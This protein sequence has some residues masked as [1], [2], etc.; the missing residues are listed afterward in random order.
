M[1]LAFRTRDAAARLI[2]LADS[3]RYVDWIGCPIDTTNVD[4]RKMLQFFIEDVALI[5][6]RVYKEAGIPQDTRATVT[7]LLRYGV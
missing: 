4:Q 5:M 7:R 1:T 3:T 6:D 2:K